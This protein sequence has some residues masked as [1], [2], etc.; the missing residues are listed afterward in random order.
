MIHKLAVVEDG[1]VVASDAQIMAFAVVK[2][3]VKISNAVKVFE[4][5]VI[6]GN[7]QH[8]KYPDTNM[9]VE[10]GEGSVIREFVTIHGGIERKT[11]IGKNC[12]LMNYAHIAHDCIIGDNVIM[13]NGVQLA[14]HVEV[15]EY[16]VFGGLAAVHQHVRIGRFAMV[17]GGS[18]VEQ[19][20]PPFVIVQGDR[21]KIRGINKV[22]LERAGIKKDEIKEIEEAYKYL[23]LK[24][25]SLKEKIKVENP[26]KFLKEFVDFIKNSKRGI[27][28]KL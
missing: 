18:M 27:A 28:A 14:G 23:F 15:A 8:I 1:A 9:G 22:G 7:P 6:G 13:A 4:H 20:V 2:S 19:D 12:Y 11:V 25:G 21:A 3:N 16:V 24:E 10:I 17:A 26:S 5:A